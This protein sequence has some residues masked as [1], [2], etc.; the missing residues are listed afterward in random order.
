MEGSGIVADAPT[1]VPIDPVADPRW[2]ELVRRHPDAGPYHLGAWAE[3]LRAA[4]GDRPAYLGLV[5]PGGE[6]V[7]GLPVMRTRGLATGSRMRS[8]PVVP[9]AGPL[10]SDDEAARILLAAA[11]HAA[12]GAGVRVWTLHAR[13]GG[14][15]RLVPELRPLPKHPTWVLDLPGDVDEMRR[16]WKKTSNNLWRSIRKADKAGVQVREGRSEE[17]LKTFYD[18]YLRTMRR[19]RVLPRPFRQLKEDRRLLGPDG[20]FRLFLAEHEGDVVAGGVYHALGEAVDLLYNGSDD[21]RL[22][23]RPNH[24]LY[25]HVIEWAAANGFAELDFGHARTG[26]SLAKF[27]AQWSAR[28]VPEYRY[29]YVPGATSAKG[30]ARQAAALEGRGGSGPLDRVWPRVPLA[31][32]RAAAALAYR[33]L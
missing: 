17:D 21:A 25:W 20:A 5:A 13:A 16:G 27:K 11:C 26:S 3:I 1:V 2:D 10:A 22:D 4:Y 14:L 28:E 6:L 24:A 12:D 31:A 9:P 32:T 19:R 29:D 33:W 8:L 23:V 18:L 30:A 15:E 7:G